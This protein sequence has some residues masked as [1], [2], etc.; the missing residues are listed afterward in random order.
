MSVPIRATALLSP[1]QWIQGWQ[2]TPRRAFR[3]SPFRR[4]QSLALGHGRYSFLRLSVKFLCSP[5]VSAS[6]ASKKPKRPQA[7]RLLQKNWRQ[8]TLAEAI[9][10]LPSAR[11]RLTAEFGMGSGRTTAL[12]PPKSYRRSQPLRGV[13]QRFCA[14]RHD[15]KSFKEHSCSLK[16][17]HRDTEH[18]SV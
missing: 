13:L 9:Q 7:S 5:V 16:T 15:F 10:P 11:L 8:P 12:W 18:F 6:S 17:T 2:E 1:V 14:A 4:K 3:Q